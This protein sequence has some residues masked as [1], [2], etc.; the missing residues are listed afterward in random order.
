MSN[1]AFSTAMQT[2]RFPVSVVGKAL[3]ALS[4]LL[5]VAC[6]EKPKPQPTSQ[7]PA[8]SYQPIDHKS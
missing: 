5:I 2:P 3:V 6:S 4:L 7:T 8:P 1:S